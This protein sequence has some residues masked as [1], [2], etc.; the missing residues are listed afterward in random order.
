LLVLAGM[1]AALRPAAA[2]SPELPPL[3]CIEAV[4]ASR[5]RDLQGDADA[6]RAGLEAAFALPGCEL[7]ALSD[8]LHLL[9]G[10][11][12]GA[13]ETTAVRA[14]LAARLEDPAVRVPAGLI[15]YLAHVPGAPADRELILA[16]LERRLSHELAA[17]AAPPVAS[18]EALRAVADLQQELGKLEASR[19]T[20]ERLLRVDP[21]EE[22]RW[23]AALL[24]V[25]LQRWQAAAASLAGLVEAPDA[26]ALLREA[27]LTV[28]AHLG[29]FAELQRQLA[30]L[31]PP[32][33]AIDAGELSAN[34]YAQ[35][36]LAAAWALRDAGRDAEAAEV[37]RRV[38]AYDPAVEEA[39]QALLHLYATPGERAAR[40]AEQQARRAAETDPVA[41][42]EEGSNLLGGGDAEAARALLARAAPQ[43]AG[44]DYAE[45][46]WYNLGNATSQ[47]ER[48]EEAA[49]AY[50]AALAVNPARAES[51]LKLGVALYR[52]ERCGEAM[53]ALQRALA[54]AP[55]L[56]VAHGYLAGCYRSLGDWAA[57][58]RENALAK[59]GG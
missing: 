46:A 57:A 10:G 1:L 32:P 36:L 47:L 3:A 49:A 44:T 42:F 31:P 7:P 33:P 20:L 5:I 43:L 13:E 28:L 45:A 11:D 2:E 34:R 58:A 14:R 17:T 15:T 40:A 9:V 19:A 59:P 55:E 24:D 27:Y 26:P 21:S 52:L 16:A 41:L 29:R 38:V 53:P 18:A 37:F 8:L 30:L 12:Y 23:R 48:W 25:A 22:L 6:A 54:L 56:R 51:H 35:T 39:Q 4:R 50:T